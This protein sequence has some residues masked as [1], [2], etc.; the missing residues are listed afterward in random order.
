MSMSMSMPMPVHAHA[1]AHV[2]VHVHVNVPVLSPSYFHNVP[3]INC[4]CIINQL[5]HCLKDPYLH[6]LDAQQL[7]FLRLAAAMLP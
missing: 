6:W 7:T 4:S 1:H 3:L 5:S 2:H